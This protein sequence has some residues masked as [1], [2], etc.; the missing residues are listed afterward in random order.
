MIASPNFGYFIY[1]GD[2]SAYN[3]TGPAGSDHIEHLFEDYFK[4]DARLPTQPSAFDGRSDY[5]PFLE[6][7]IPSG[8]LFTGAEVVKTPEQVKL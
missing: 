3:L 7:G 6:A 5:G 8:G 1:D 2:G 4:K